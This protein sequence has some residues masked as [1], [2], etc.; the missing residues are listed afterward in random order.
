LE[1]SYYMSPEKITTGRHDMGAEIY[2]LGST[3]YHLICGRPPFNSDS[4]EENVRARFESSVTAPEDIQEH[5]DPELADLIKSMLSIYPSDRPANYRELKDQLTSIRRR[6]K[7]SASS[8]KPRSIS[9]Q[10]PEVRHMPAEPE[11]APTRQVAPQQKGSAKVISISAERSDAGRPEYFV[12]KGCL[13]YL[14]RL[15]PLAVIT[16][17][18]LLLYAHFTDDGPVRRLMEP[19]LQKIYETNGSQN[20]VP[21]DDKTDKSTPPGDADKST[22]SDDAD[23]STPPGDADEGTTP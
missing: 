22:P 19:V 13:Y 9:T 15:I 14:G 5:I 20:N 2:S 23:K 6:L 17:I 10:A 4:A 8:S 3:M 7:G 16:F 1:M 21:K 12:R 11:D 18:T